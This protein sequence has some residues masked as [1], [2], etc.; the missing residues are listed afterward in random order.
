[1]AKLFVEAAN[2]GRARRV[3]GAFVTVDVYDGVSL[4]VTQV[5]PMDDGSGDK[6][7]EGL[8]IVVT[9]DVDDITTYPFMWQSS[10][11]PPTIPD[12]LLAAGI[13]SLMQDPKLSLKGVSKEDADH[14][15]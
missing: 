1:M 2:A 10:G 7:L 12:Q 9:A 13:R 15:R 4:A 8:Y 14:G 11:G 5:Q 3:F 6:G